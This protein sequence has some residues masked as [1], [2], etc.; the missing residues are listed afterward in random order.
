MVILIM[1]D[2]PEEAAR[3]KELIDHVKPAEVP[4]Q[5]ISA[6]TFRMLLS[7]KGWKANSPNTRKK[8]AEQFKIDTRIAGG[9]IQFKNQP[10][11]IPVR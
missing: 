1:A 2:T 7:Q 6:V 11:K 9:C 5:W 10:D 3:V 4:E 8:L